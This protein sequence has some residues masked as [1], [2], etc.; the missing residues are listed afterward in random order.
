MNNNTQA[1]SIPGNTMHQYIEVITT[2][3]SVSHDLKC[4]YNEKRNNVTVTY[5]GITLNW[6]KPQHFEDWSGI[7]ALESGINYWVDVD[8]IP[9][10]FTHADVVAISIM[11][12]DVRQQLFMAKTLDEIDIAN[13]IYSLQN[14]S[15]IP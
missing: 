1:A 13:G 8:G 4:M 10:N 6:S 14:I 7:L 2:E 11:I 3:S 9:H 15:A 12:K 5:N